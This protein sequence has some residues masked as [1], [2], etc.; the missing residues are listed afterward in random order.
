MLVKLFVNENQG[1]GRVKAKE[2]RVISVI[3]KNFRTNYFS[4]LIEIKYFHTKIKPEK[5][6]TDYKLS[7]FFPSSYIYPY[8]YMYIITYSTKKKVQR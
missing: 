4:E 3:D 5:Y 2:E 1:N 6:I 7:P 8:T